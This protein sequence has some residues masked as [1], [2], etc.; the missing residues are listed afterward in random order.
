MRQ[1]CQDVWLNATLMSDY[2]GVEVLIIT[3]ARFPNEGDKV[4]ELGGIPVLIT[5][6]DAPVLD[7]ESD[8]AMDGWNKWVVHVENEATLRELNAAAEKLAAKIIELAHG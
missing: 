8:K 2:P 1:I 3:D 7:T 4:I 5:K 6:S